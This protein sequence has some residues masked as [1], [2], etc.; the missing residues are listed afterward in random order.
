MKIRYFRNR[1]EVRREYGILIAAPDSLKMAQDFA[2]Q[3]APA[4]I[5]QVGYWEYFSDDYLVN[6]RAYVEDIYA[7]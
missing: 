7:K 4:N 5:E 1:Y 6:E 3:Y 2:K